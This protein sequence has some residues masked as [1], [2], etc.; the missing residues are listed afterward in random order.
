MENRTMEN[1]RVIE[2]TIDAL[3]ALRILENVAVATRA[4]DYADE[5]AKPIQT[6]CCTCCGN[7]FR[8]RQWWNMDTGFGLGDCCVKFCGVKP[9]GGESRSFGVPGIHFL[10][11]PEPR[12]VPAL[13]LGIDELRETAETEI[14]ANRNPDYWRRVLNAL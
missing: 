3:E 2:T 8:G 13:F 9:N 10:I 11:H 12:E 4:D 6:L 7:W 1:V 5:R 14:S